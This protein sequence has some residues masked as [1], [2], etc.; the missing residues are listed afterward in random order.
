MGLPSETV[1]RYLRTSRTLFEGIECGG[2]MI[3]RA[4]INDLIESVQLRNGIP[5]DFQGFETLIWL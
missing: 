5:N 2:K 3:K 4:K 1:L